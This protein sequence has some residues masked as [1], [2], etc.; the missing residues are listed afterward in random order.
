MERDVRE[1]KDRCRRME[2]RL[3]KYL[4]EQGF[5]TQ[6]KMPTCQGNVVTIPSME[7]SLAD[8][9]SV[10]PVPRVPGY[11]SI[12]ISHKGVTVGVLSGF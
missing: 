8:I 1:I 11:D 6:R 10:M 4:E 7:C 5:D 2:T 12:V 9:L 3:T